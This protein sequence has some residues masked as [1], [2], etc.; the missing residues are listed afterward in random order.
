MIQSVH[1]YGLNAQ[2]LS[3]CLLAQKHGVA[4]TGSDLNGDPVFVDEI[5]RKLP[6]IELFFGEHPDEP[7]DSAEY[8][9]VSPGVV[10]DSEN[11]HKVSDTPHWISGVDFAFIVNQWKNPRIIVTGSYGKTTFCTLLQHLLS[12]IG[13][14]AVVAG[15]FE[16]PLTDVEVVSPDEIMILEL[17]YQQLVA[18]KLLKADAAV[19]LNIHAGDN[20]F[21]CDELY[22]KTKLSVLNLLKG[23]GQA[24]V[25]GEVE[26][27]AVRQGFPKNQ[28]VVPAEMPLQ[29]NSLIPLKSV[30]L[31]T[32]LWGFLGYPSIS[33][34]EWMELET[35][36]PAG[37]LNSV[38]VDPLLE[39][40]ND[41]S[42]KGPEAVEHL[43]GKLQIRANPILITSCS[44]VR[45]DGITLV[46]LA[47][48]S[49]TSL[50]VAVKKALKL[51]E[52][53]QSV[54]AYSPG[55]SSV[56]KGVGSIMDRINRFEELI[57]K[58]RH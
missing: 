40:I 10:Q 27:I 48:Y 12:K 29:G 30:E 21:G 55:V 52:N 18:T 25:P 19:I 38:S 46:H 11:W 32:A 54:I 2:G 44:N 36:L 45:D 34:K 39:L 37:R 5:S 16:N 56:G 35:H 22:A 47:D 26:T 31:M 41:G 17:D 50:E 58:H 1:I 24:F 53:L 15:N 6:G 20:V 8:V 4:I 57:K 33:K 7:L 13:K 23:N 14:T 28:L 9:V 51:A 43:I 42:S 49:E 3:A